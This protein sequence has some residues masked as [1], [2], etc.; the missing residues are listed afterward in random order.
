MVIFMCNLNC[1][2]RIGHMCV[3]LFF[4]LHSHVLCI[5][6]RVHIY[7]YIYIYKYVC[8]H[9]YVCVCVCC[10]HMHI[11]IYIYI[12]TSIRYLDIYIQP[13]QGMGLGQPIALSITR[14]PIW[15]MGYDKPPY[16]RSVLPVVFLCTPVISR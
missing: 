6:M 10:M 16:L 11:Y 9:T 2:P 5:N 12:C 7:I 8:I 3:F 1:N 13:L 4:S 14:H 15:G